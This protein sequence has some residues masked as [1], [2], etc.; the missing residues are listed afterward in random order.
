M[1]KIGKGPAKVNV[2]P[3]IGQLNNS[4]SYSIRPTKYTPKLISGHYDRS[5]FWGSRSD[6]LLTG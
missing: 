1:G 5:R 2:D 3:C 6:S 4:L